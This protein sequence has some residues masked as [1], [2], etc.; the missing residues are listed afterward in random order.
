M[1]IGKTSGMTYK[2]MDLFL[3]AHRILAD[4]GH[5]EL[6][7]GHLSVLDRDAGIMWIKRGDMNFGSVDADDIVGVDL[8]ANKVAGEGPLHTELWLH[9]SI[10]AA[11]SDVN[12]IAHSHASSLVAY[13][14]VEPVWPVIDQYTLEM[15]NGLSW[16]DRSGLIVT[17]E[18]GE[19]LAGAL[20]S[21]R[22]CVL[23][24]H[25]VVVADASIEAAVVGIVQFGR[26]VEI[27]RTARMLG[28][29]RPMPVEDE[30]PMRARFLERRLSRVRNMWGALAR[31]SE[32]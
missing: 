5:D 19:S 25:G 11:R 20:G 12:A 29:V 10:Y 14:A 28:N 13:S 27:Q 7:F 2:D 15:S 3:D 23:R 30:V 16:Y 4:Q 22:T 9:L 32:I 26:S 8:A 1:P 31:E 21:G 6:H 17:K 24:S 18:L